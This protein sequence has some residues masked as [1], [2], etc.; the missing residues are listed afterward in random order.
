MHPFVQFV[1]FNITFSLD[2]YKHFDPTW[3]PWP[4]LTVGTDTL[5]KTLV[6]QPAMLL[7]A[8]LWR[9]AFSIRF[10]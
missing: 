7:S 6:H 4:N 9:R 8:H 10:N 2:T 5:W 3:Q 1:L